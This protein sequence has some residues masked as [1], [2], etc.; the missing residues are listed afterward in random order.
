MHDLLSGAL[1]AHGGLDR[2][3][4]FEAVSA[5]VVTGGEFWATKGIAM[6]AF[7]R[8][9]TAATRREWST[10]AP[11]GDPDW[12]MT[13]VPDRVV[14]ESGDGVVAERADPRAAFE[15]H[16][17]DTPW[18]P[19]HRAYFNGYALWTYLT[20]PFLLAMEG[21]AVEEAEPWREGDEVWRVLRAT[22]PAA[23]ATHGRRQDFYF[24]PDFLVRRHDYQV[25]VSGGFLAAHYIHGMQAFDGLL[26][27]AERRAHPRGPDR[28]PDRSRVLVSID[29]SDYR[30]AEAARPGGRPAGPDRRPTHRRRRCDRDRRR[31]PPQKED[32]RPPADDGAQ[33]LRPGPP[34]SDTT[35]I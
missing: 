3:N 4:A 9:A 31:A 1:E 10:V 14:V 16:G 34:D 30:C 12:R 8:R 11:Y 28:R 21:V 7:P 23:I 24:G 32:R 6:D 17:L 35:P 19:L 5:S 26:F 27:P 25:E 33:H 20:T 29:L 18:D 2:W 13:F 15:G 22:L